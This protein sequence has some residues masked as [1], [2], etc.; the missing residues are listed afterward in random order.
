M[1]FG[2]GGILFIGLLGLCAWA[3]HKITR[4]F[5]VAGWILPL[6]LLSLILLPLLG[7]LAEADAERRGAGFMLSAV[8]LG[9]FGPA[10]AGGLIGATVATVRKVSAPADHPSQRSK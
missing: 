3:G 2:L 7:A 6:V 8:M 1:F 10:V 4:R 5:P 9:F